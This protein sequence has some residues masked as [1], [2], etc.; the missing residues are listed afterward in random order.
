MSE[1]QFRR[2][3]KGKKSKTFR[4]A[5]EIRKA[6]TEVDRDD[7]VITFIR[8]IQKAAI[9]LATTHGATGDPRLDNI[10]RRLEQDPE[11]APTIEVCAGLVTAAVFYAEVHGLD[12]GLKNRLIA[13]DGDDL[14]DSLQDPDEL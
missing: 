9:E 5:E 14:P 12:S 11:Y 6:K 1:Q 10:R 7:A 4:L 13:M 8:N 2:V 3:R